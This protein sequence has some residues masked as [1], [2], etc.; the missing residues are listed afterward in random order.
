MHS[1]TNF[2]H[3]YGK[4]HLK[5]KVVYLFCGTVTNW[6]VIGIKNQDIRGSSR[7]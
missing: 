4:K 5:H 6:Y 2:L 3:G 7:W 1:G